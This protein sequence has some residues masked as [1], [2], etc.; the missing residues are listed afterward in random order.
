MLE[1]TLRGI[2][3]FGMV[4]GIIFIHELGHYL[5]GRWVVGIPQ[6][7]ITIV[8]TEVPQHVALRADNKWVGPNEFEQYSALYEEYDPDHEYLEL[9]IG[10]GELVQT[11]G[12][13]TIAATFVG[14]GLHG[15]AT[16]LVVISLL[17][18]GLY[19]AWDVVG[20]V[21]TGRPIGDYS[22]LWRA[23]P[24]AAVAVFLGFL[25]PHIL[26]YLWI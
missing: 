8:M 21:Y 11:I 14:I 1:F 17:M 3:A 13:V 23:S 19:L 6:T 26:I 4:F 7:D 18:A 5:A 12:V 2:L 9:Y 10:A 16:S 22:A 24:L 20:S 15:V 25:L